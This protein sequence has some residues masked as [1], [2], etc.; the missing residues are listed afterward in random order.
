MQAFRSC[1]AVDLCT[2][3]SLVLILI[4]GSVNVFDLL[5]LI[6]HLED[7]DVDLKNDIKMDIIEI[8]S[9]YMEWFHRF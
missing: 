8:G 3:I 5:Y 6:G 2:L 9:E 1:L 4:S 7:L